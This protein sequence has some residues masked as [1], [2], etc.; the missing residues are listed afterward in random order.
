[1]I[2]IVPQHY[3]WKV[4]NKEIK[5]VRLG[6]ALFQVAGI[7]GVAF[8]RGYKYGFYPWVNQKFFN[9]PLPLIDTDIVYGNFKNPSTYL[10][11]DLGFCG[12]DVPDNVIVDGYFGSYR[13]W[14]RC[15]SL[16]RY[17]FQLKK[18][19]YKPLRDCIIIQYRDYGKEFP[20]FM[21]LNWENYYEKALSLM[22][23]KKIYV[24]TDNPVAAKKDIKLDCE[25]L[26]ISP[27][28]DFFLI[29]NADYLIMS[30][31]TFSWWGAYLSEA[32][33]V[34]P[35]QWFDPNGAFADCPINNDDFYFD[36]W[37]VV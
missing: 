19:I 21:H 5:D 32:E 15:Q 11:F 29:C 2:S 35:A 22:P 34:A 23:D 36:Y 33:T 8:N 27:I 37:K 14:E 12:F 13:Y 26:N 25:Y 1:M 9:N 17:F 18:D 24:V 7:I 10:D 3:S 31:S 20:D 28:V 16:I 4:D 30:N 6:N